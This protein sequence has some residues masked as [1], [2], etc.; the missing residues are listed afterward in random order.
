MCW[1]LNVNNT[2]TLHHI[3]ARA[4]TLC[5]VSHCCA[6][7]ADL[8][9]SLLLFVQNAHTINIDLYTGVVVVV[10]HGGFMGERARRL[11]LGNRDL[12]RVVNVSDS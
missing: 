9:V 10:V 8:I 1:S 5:V 7:V 6:N 4:Y 12:S 2:N 3:D 11:G